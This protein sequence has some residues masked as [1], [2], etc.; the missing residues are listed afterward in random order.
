MEARRVSHMRTPREQPGNGHI[1]R[2]RAT[3]FTVFAHDLP[4]VVRPLLSSFGNSWCA[5]PPKPAN[6]QTWCA[7]M[8][9]MSPDGGTPLLTPRKRAIGARLGN[10]RGEWRG[11]EAE[12]NTFKNQ[13]LDRSADRIQV[14]SCMGM[15]LQVRVSVCR[16]GCVAVWLCGCVAVWLCGCVVVWLCGCVAVWLCG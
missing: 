2:V 14:F 12:E 15:R 3:R 9:S 4:Y 7:S 1:T 13:L 16:C 10:A 6:S 8:R 5:P 11:E